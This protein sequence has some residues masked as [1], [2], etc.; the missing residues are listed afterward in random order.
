MAIVEAFREWRHYLSGTR[1]T[2][3]VYTD[4]KNLTYFTTTKELNK[5]QIRWAEELADYDF[6]IHYR[7]GS[8]NGRADALS[9]RS[10][11]LPSEAPKQQ[12]I[13]VKR[14]NGTITLANRQ[15]LA[16]YTLQ[17]DETWKIRLQS[18]YPTDT[19]WEQNHDRMEQLDG[20]WY[21]DNKIYV[22]KSQQEALIQHIH[23]AK[24]SGHPGIWK[25]KEWIKRHYC[26]L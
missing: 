17:P 21:E 24:T 8:E 16:L 19:Y 10:D 5:R 1:Y 13:L 25:T 2:V 18:A 3:R 15:L 20:L 4:H 9:R 12:S 22:P 11:H 7:K 26:F 14:P 6:E 23:E